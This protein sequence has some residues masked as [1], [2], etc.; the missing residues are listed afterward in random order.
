MKAFMTG[1]SLRRRQRKNEYSTPVFC[2]IGSTILP[3]LCKGR[4]KGDCFFSYC[5]NRHSKICE[6]MNKYQHTAQYSLLPCNA[7]W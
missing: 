5:F 3:I 1:A 7:V 4:L 2:Y 6:E